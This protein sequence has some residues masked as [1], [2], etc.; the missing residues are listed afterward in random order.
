MGDSKKRSVCKT[1]SWRLI[2]T[3]ITSVVSFAI[4]GNLVIAISIGS[5]DTLV[6]LFA[7]YFHERGWEKIGF[8]RHKTSE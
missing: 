6:K 5:I 3:V 4:T 2:A 8:G 7:Y 1:V